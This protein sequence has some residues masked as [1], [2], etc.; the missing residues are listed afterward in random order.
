MEQPFPYALLTPKKN[1]SLVNSSRTTIRTVYISMSTGR[2]SPVLCSFTHNSLSLA[3]S[4]FRSN[5]STS[6]TVWNKQNKN[7]NV[8]GA[9]QVDTVTALKCRT[10][11]GMP[12]WHLL[13]TKNCMYLRPG[14]N[15][16]NGKPCSRKQKKG[17][18]AMSGRDKLPIPGTG[19]SVSWL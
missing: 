8:K 5:W 9:F 13:T 10:A 15:G 3:G 6:S 12:V 14:D 16:Q 18:P 4:T 7:Q 2:I 1:I 19:Q 17:R 11:L